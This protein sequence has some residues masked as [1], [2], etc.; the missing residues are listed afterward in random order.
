MHTKNITVYIKD[1]KLIKEIEKYPE[2]NWS[3]VC[4]NAIRDYIKKRKG[5]E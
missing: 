4:R 5:G 1:E 2:V 3:A